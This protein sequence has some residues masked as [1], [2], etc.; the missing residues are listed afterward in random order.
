MLIV[1]ISIDKERNKIF[2]N[3]LILNLI[4]YS[5]FCSSILCR[6]LLFKGF[7]FFFMSF[8]KKNTN[9]FQKKFTNN[10]GKIS[11]TNIIWKIYQYFVAKIN[12]T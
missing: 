5:K 8:N 7:F 3:F 6:I 1:Q 10:F 12:H 4:I 9:F 11:A 2:Y